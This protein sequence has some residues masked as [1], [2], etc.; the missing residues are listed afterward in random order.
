M[1][2]SNVWVTRDGDE[3]VVRREGSERASSRHETQ[4]DAL[5]AGRQTA[6]REEVELIWQGRDG[7]IQGRNS[8][9]N[10]PNPPKG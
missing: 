6:R 4:G 8:Y 1:S 5:D 3:W 2:K 9:G 10:D 7:K